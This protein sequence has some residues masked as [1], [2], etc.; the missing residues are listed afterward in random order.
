MHTVVSHYVH[1]SSIER[2]VSIGVTESLRGE[3]MHKLHTDQKSHGMDWMSEQTAPIFINYRVSHQ[4]L[5][6]A[7]PIGLFSG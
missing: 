1:K 2:M 3:Y 7:R 4:P 6:E 5:A